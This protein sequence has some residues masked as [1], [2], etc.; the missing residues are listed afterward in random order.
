MSSDS[1]TG[2]SAPEANRLLPLE[3]RT[4]TPMDT[5]RCPVYVRS[6]PPCK[7]ACPSSEDIRGH[8]TR[9]AQSELF[10]R[11]LEQSLD[12][13]WNII[14]DKNPFPAIIGRICPHP[15]ESACNRRRR[16]WPLAIHNIERHAGDHGIER[17]LALRRL[18]AETTAQQDAVDTIST[19]RN[20]LSEAVT[21]HV[22][23]VGAG[24]SGLSCAYQ[25]A[26]RGIPVTVFE[27]GS[28]AGGMLRDGIPLYRLPREVIDAEVGRIVELG[29]TIRYGVRIGKDI[30]LEE[31]RRDYDAVYVATGAYESVRLEVEGEDLPA[32]LTAL[33]FL[34]RANRRELTEA[35]PRVLVIGGGN[36]AIDAARVAVR[37]GADV[38]IVY[39]RSRLEM[40][41][42]P[43]EVWE[44]EEEG[45][46]FEFQTAPVRISA[47]RE[48]QQRGGSSLTM[49][50]IRTEAGPADESGRHSPV[51]I[52]GSEFSLEADMV[53]VA[54]GQ[55]HQ[56]AGIESILDEHDDVS[57][58]TSFATG[59]PGVFA[60][61]DMLNPGIATTAIGQGRKAARAIVDFLA[62]VDH[63]LP[64]VPHPIDARQMRLDH[65]EVMQRNDHD[66]EEAATRKQDFR[67]VNLPLTRD[68][69]VAESKRCMSCGRCFVCDRCRIYCPWEAISK[70]LSRPIGF[71]MFTDY[72]KCSGCG[73]CAMTCPCRYIQMDYS[74]SGTPY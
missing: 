32:V 36:A 63:K 7:N 12:D 73:I 23:V 59:I 56:S 64:Y 33:D 8:L 27:A 46:S 34:R 43:H 44:G 6:L 72:A 60:G 39:R 28:E 14:A 10:G 38:T 57:T 45:I 4:L 71:N 30:T 48:E 18:T 67:E 24:P 62:G 66:V 15:C 50:F 52:E 51:P 29:V 69:A 41:A 58:S 11:S 9:I 19:D 17:G 61:G 3:E 54:A 65:Y 55:R 22:A 2:S 13:A 25:L 70:D 53:I 42:I 31:L 26:R 74:N 47:S 37:L 40:P 5:G 16:D 21:K 20:R 35:G 1:E 49:E 68:A